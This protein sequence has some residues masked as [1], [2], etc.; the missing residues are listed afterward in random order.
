LNEAIDGVK[1]WTLLRR[2]VLAGL[3]ILGAARAGQAQVTPAAGHTPPDDTPSIKVGVVIYTDYTYTD[4]PTTT[5][6][7][8]NTINSSAFNVSR[9]Y[10]NVT[11]NL[12]HLVAFRVT[13]DVTRETGTGSTLNG[14]LTFRLKYAFG[15][16]NF[17]DFLTHG[18]W[19]RIGVQQTP[20]VDFME[21]IY[22]YRFQGTIFEEREGF[23]TSSDFGVSAHYNLPG[24]YGDIH[25]GFYNGEGYSHVEAN[26]QKS[27]QV[28]G[29]LRPLPLGGALKGLRLTAFYD[30]DKYV[31]DG[32][33]NRFI[34][35][36]SFEHKYVTAAFDYL[37]TTDRTAITASDVKANGW[38]VWATPK[39][40]S[41]QESKS[42]LEGLIRYDNEKP[43]KAVDA[44]RKRLIVG[45][46]YW[47]PLLRGPSAALLVDMDR[48]TFDAA[49][50]QPT[51]RKYA[52]H[53]LF[54]F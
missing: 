22:R 21:G 29:T 38:S 48:Q 30:A 7:D 27:F 19:A 2:T 35:S 39:F 51:N 54:N 33:R 31:K 23:L 41:L 4:T 45:V 8:K 26:D 1:G 50:K 9:S 40:L 3:L 43:N 15:Q 37:S 6:S 32:P 28:R 46:G 42:G 44:R 34:G 49:L 5:D 52:L 24:N 16:V 36:A 18:S 12:S 25:A 11:G 17:D 20:Y 14:S 47:F 10:I 53:A 13:P